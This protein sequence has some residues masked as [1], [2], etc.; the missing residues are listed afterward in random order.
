VEVDH[1]TKPRQASKTS[2]A[3]PDPT[4]RCLA[5]TSRDVQRLGPV[6]TAREEHAR[7][8]LSEAGILFG[9]RASGEARDGSDADVAVMAGREVGLLEREVLADGLVRALGVPDVDLALLDD[10]SLELRG[11]VVQEGRLLFSVDEPRRVASR[12]APGPSTS[13]SC[14]ACG[15]TRAVT[16]AR[17]PSRACRHPADRWYHIWHDPY[18]G[19]PR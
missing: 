18:D 6:T 8:V 9:S 5:V 12:C 16:Y 10:A 1:A 3:R 7:E 15:S 4:I 19:L 2:R 11:A 17:W 13:T 14:P